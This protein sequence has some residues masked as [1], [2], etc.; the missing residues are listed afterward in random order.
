MNA[1]SRFMTGQACTKV[2]LGTNVL[3]TVLKLWAGIT[4]GSQALIADGINSLSDI[5]VSSVVYL[6]YKISREPADKEHPYG[7]GNAETIA[8]LAVSVGVVATGAVVAYSSATTLLAGVHT[9]P[10]RLALY[11]AAFSIVIK[12]ILHRYTRVVAETEHSPSL[13]AS[14]KDYRSDVLATSAAFFGIV[15]ARLGLPLL[16]PVAGL[17]IAALIV[18]MGILVLKENVYILMAGAPTSGITEEVLGTV[19]SFDGVLGVPQIRLQ[20]MGGS[21]VVNVDITVDGKIPVAEG[22][23]IAESL[24]RRCLEIHERVS[25]VIVHVEPYRREPEE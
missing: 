10:G 12:E 16:D 19:R 22:H 8:G 4:A 18:R 9:V 17:V 6:A 7:H 14:A 5:V 15:G 1:K 3:L 20:R 25:E 2:G 24:R 23:G 11:V 13:K 21:Y